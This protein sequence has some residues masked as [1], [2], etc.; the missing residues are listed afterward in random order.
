LFITE[1]DYVIVYRTEPGVIVIIAL[2][3][4]SRDIESALQQRPL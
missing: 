4:G 2:L 3:H 1:G